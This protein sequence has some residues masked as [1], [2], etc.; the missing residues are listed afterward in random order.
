MALSPVRIPF[1]NMKFKPDLP[2][3]TLAPDEYNA[4]RNIETNIRGINSVYG[5]ELILSNIPGNIVYMD[6]GYRDNLNYVFI[7][8][9]LEG[10]IYQVSA[11]G[12]TDVTPTVITLTG[13]T[14]DTQFTSCWS[15]DV[16]FLNDTINPP[17]YLIPSETQFRVYGY[18]P[19]N[20]VW[21]YNPAWSSVS[22]GF[23][24]LYATTNVGSILVAGNL[25]AITTGGQTVRL[26]TTVQWSQSFG[27][28]SGPT[29]WAPTITNIANQ[30]EIP[31]KGPIVDGFVC[32]GNFIAMSQWEAVIF[33]PI[34]Y[35]S[36][37]APILGIQP[38]NQSRGLLNENAWANADRK[39][40][41]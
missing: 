38:L 41:V 31:I 18:P 20:Y 16:L 9:T 26:P 25:T 17:M 22:A 6:A 36:T 28:N 11:A 4:G 21:N 15:G 32:N 29:T 13:Y 39:S 19:D 10:H 5:D 23:L 8:V 37:S 40:V 34:A 33:A 30:L 3:N 2:S 1:T 24:R 7:V 27:V 14:Q 35:T 12:I